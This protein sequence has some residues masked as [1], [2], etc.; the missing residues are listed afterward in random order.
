MN[1]SII[2]MLIVHCSSCGRK[3]NKIK[4]CM[5]PRIYTFKWIKYHSAVHANRNTSYHFCPPNACKLICT[6]EE[7]IIII[8]RIC[9]FFMVFDFIIHY[10]HSIVV[11]LFRTK[12]AYKMSR[13][14]CE[15][16]ISRENM[17]VSIRWSGCRNQTWTLNIL[18]KPKNWKQMRK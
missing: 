9:G 7:K 3:Q 16:K 1:I 6:N 8:M 11:N 18:S 10:Y 17:S 12:N 14:A 5:K 15:C 2:I 13:C 4:M